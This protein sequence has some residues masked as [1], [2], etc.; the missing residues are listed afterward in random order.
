VHGAVDLAAHVGLLGAFLEGSDQPHLAQRRA[1]RGDRQAAIEVGQ[2]GGGGH[3]AAVAAASGTSCARRSRVTVNVSS[4]A[5]LSA[6][7]I[8]PSQWA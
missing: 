3:A 8:S 1:Q 2:L 4:G 6:V 7:S 5:Q